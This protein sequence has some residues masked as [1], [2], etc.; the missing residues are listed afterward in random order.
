[1]S[2]P[3]RIERTLQIA[4]PPGTVW[5]ALTTAEGLGTWFGNEASIDL[6]PGGS[7][8]IQDLRKEATDP[9]IAAE[10][11]G[12]NQ[13]RVNTLI[14]KWI[15]RTALPRSCFTVFSTAPSPPQPSKSDA[16]TGP[17]GAARSVRS[18]TKRGPRSSTIT[19]T[20]TTILSR[21]SWPSSA[22]RFARWADPR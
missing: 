5:T 18:A 19:P 7:A 15:F 9:E 12:M 10:V 21:N 20:S 22:C 16:W 6:R 14:T 2:F 8:S 1:M 13:G 3:D 4:H 11:R 17:C